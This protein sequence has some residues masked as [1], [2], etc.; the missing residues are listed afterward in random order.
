MHHH[1]PI[2]VFDSGVGGV[3]VLH[4][5]RRILPGEDIDY[6]ADSGHCP[7]GSRSADF[8]RARALHITQFLIARGAKAIV[9]ACNTATAA[10]VPALRAACSIPIIGM[11][12]GVKPAATITRSG[13]VGV[14]A[15]TNTS[16]SERL[17]HLIERYAGGVKV[18]TQPCPGLPEQVEAGDL[19][20][21]ETHRLLR[22]YT[23]PLIAQG[24]D[25]LVLG[26]T[27]Y[28]FLRPTLEALLGPAVTIIDTGPAVARQTQRILTQHV[29]LSGKQH[30]AVRFW[31][32]APVANTAAVLSTLW[33]A[34][35]DLH[36][37]PSTV[38]HETP[39]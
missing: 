37:L 24:A 17:A 30:G 4:E 23:D 34:P 25:V 10:A 29:L 12:P 1:G 38:A 16:R 7:Y 27:H 32:S 33:P 5:L 31:T 22:Q 2:G 6:V 8:I 14:L 15:T 39:A 21:P 26:C 18:L 28:P 11:E 35:I 19:Y 13:I 9:V 36:A 3:S 20:G